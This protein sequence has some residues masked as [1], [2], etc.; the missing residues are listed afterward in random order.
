MR[1]SLF[2]RSCFSNSKL[3]RQTRRL[4]RYIMI[5]FTL[6]FLFILLNRTLLGNTIRVKL[7]DLLI[8]LE[9]C[10]FSAWILPKIRYILFECPICF[11][12]WSGLI[13]FFILETGFSWLVVTIIVAY[14]CETVIKLL[15]K[16]H[17]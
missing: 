10:Q 15:N 9:T 4:G 12:W 14:F 6:Y 3:S 2:V 13:L 7:T 5:Y 17:S 8:S 11:I 1:T 16:C